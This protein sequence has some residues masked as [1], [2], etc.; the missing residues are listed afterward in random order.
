[1]MQSPG[2]YHTSRHYN[3]GPMGDSQ[4]GLRDNQLDMY[5]EIQ[6]DRGQL[7]A[8]VLVFPLFPSRHK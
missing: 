4:T 3:L 5:L 7:D 2:N 1:M 8:C 6:M